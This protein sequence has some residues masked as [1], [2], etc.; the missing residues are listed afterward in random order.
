ML[1]VKQVASWGLLMALTWGSQADGASA[2]F[3][4][5]A[6]SLRYTG[7]SVTS[8]A[9]SGRSG[10]PRTTND[11]AQ[12]LPI[13]GVFFSNFGNSTCMV[14]SRTRG[15]SS[16]SVYDDMHQASSCP[17]PT[18]GVVSRSVDAPGATFITGLEVCLPNTPD[19][20]TGDRIAGVR[21]HLS[22][23]EADGTVV[24]MNTSES[25]VAPDC[26]NWQPRVDCPANSLAVN[27]LA[28]ANPQ[29]VIRGGLALSCAPLVG[30][31]LRAPLDGTNWGIDFTTRVNAS[32]FTSPSGASLRRIETDGI[33][34]S[35]VI[36]RGS[37]NRICAVQAVVRTITQGSPAGHPRLYGEMFRTGLCAQAGQP[38]V[39]SE[40]SVTEG[41]AATAFR[42]GGTLGV[43]ALGGGFTRTV[44]ANGTIIYA[45]NQGAALET[46]ALFP[47]LPFQTGYSGGQLSDRYCPADHAATGIIMYE[48][49]NGYTDYNLTCSPIV[50]PAVLTSGPRVRPR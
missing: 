21:I 14:K 27:V 13:A 6:R 36:G 45:A 23:V 26:A 49:N 29:G 47:A 38:V 5:F 18:A 19:T 37:D 42:I 46:V 43:T 17:L 24:S 30:P 32:G 35:T 12:P 20:T 44:H 41:P 48:V 10:S 25:A 7:S 15:P 8:T 3:N 9:V 50:R 33:Y 40:P 39:W 34:H 31:P 16:T 11:D 22:R 4:R 28:Q 2:Q 1:K